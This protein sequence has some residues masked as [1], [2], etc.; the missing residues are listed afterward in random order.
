MGAASTWSTPRECAVAVLLMWMWM[1]VAVRAAVLG[2]TRVGLSEA[3]CRADYQPGGVGLLFVATGDF[4]HDGRDDIARVSST[5][6]QLSWLRNLGGGALNDSVV[7]QLGANVAVQTSL[8]LDVD[9]D[10][11]LDI[12]LA[13]WHGRGILWY[14]NTGGDR[15]EK[16]L[17]LV[18]QSVATG[19]F[20]NV[21]LR[22]MQCARDE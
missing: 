21:C 3:G 1:C 18:G 13:L 17:L 11:W 16:V 8:V 4:D 19:A 22:S 20:D 15:F 7:D 2:G 5:S 6:G 9:G 14:R 12:V 10:G